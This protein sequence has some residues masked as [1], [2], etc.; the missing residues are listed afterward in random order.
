M[1]SLITEAGKGADLVF[2]V[3][4]EDVCPQAADPKAKDLKIAP[5]TFLEVKRFAR[6]DLSDKPIEPGSDLTADPS[7]AVMRK[8]GAAV[9]KSG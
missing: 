6:E 5:G 2:L 1:I 8:P 9:K 7:I 4:T 3:P